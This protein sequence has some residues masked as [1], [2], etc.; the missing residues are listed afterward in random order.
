MQGG[1]LG[2]VCGGLETD[3]VGCGD[4]HTKGQE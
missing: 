2:S 1:L 4:S 3:D